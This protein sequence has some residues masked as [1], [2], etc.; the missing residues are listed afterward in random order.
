MKLTQVSQTDLSSL[1][2]W[3]TKQVFLYLK[4]VYPS[5]KPSEPASEAIIWD[6]IL[7][8]AA[9][10]W[11]PIHYIHPPLKGAKKAK[12]SKANPAKSP[13]PA[14]IL[15]LDNQRPKYQ[16]TDISG[17]LQNRT[18]VTLELGW[19]VQPWVGA[20]VWENYQDFGMWQ[21]LIGGK[22]EAFDLPAIGAK[23]GK[24][25]DLD[26]EKGREGHRLMAGQEQP[27]RKNN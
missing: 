22:S 12:N 21:G 1:F 24:K 17:K 5:T 11:N 26:I 13:Y 23:G 15:K 9:A 19:N 14:G 4:A 25:K 10:P 20:L 2:N 8:G 7:P 6:A 3:N 18:D 27:R 16:I